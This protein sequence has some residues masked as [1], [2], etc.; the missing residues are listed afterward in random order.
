MYL[1]HKIEGW[2]DGWID[3]GMKQTKIL[4]MTSLQAEFIGIYKYCLKKNWTLFDHL[5][6][7]NNSIIHW[8][9]FDGGISSSKNLILNFGYRIYYCSRITWKRI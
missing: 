6:Q 5:F 3:A 9:H 4:V 2:R 7:E 1:A 8:V